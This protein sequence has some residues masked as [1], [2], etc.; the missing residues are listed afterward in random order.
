MMKSRLASFVGA[1]ALSLAAALT[2]PAQV[3]ATHVPISPQPGFDPEE[4]DRLVHLEHSKRSVL[5]GVIAEQVRLGVAYIRLATRRLA[6]GHTEEG[7]GGW[8]EPAYLG[9]KLVS[10]GIH[11]LEVKADK[12]PAEAA[13]TRRQ[14]KALDLGRTPIRH[15]IDGAK[16]TAEG[17]ERDLQFAAEKLQE[18][19]RLLQ[20]AQ[21]ALH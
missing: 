15:A 11:G 9:Y 20:S 18:G 17:N 16:R 8:R 6:A 13:W 12:Y 19:L 14:I 10:V 1:G 5:Q 7:P 2:L 4:A 21:V 3:S